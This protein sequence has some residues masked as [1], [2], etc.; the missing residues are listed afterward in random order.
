MSASRTLERAC[1]VLVIIVDKLSTVAFNLFSSA[2]IF[3]LEAD[4]IDRAPS[5]TAIALVAPLTV[6]MDMFPTVLKDDESSAVAAENEFSA[7]PDVT[8]KR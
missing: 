2:P 8:V 1:S 6:L 7:L 3:D 5:R 4:I